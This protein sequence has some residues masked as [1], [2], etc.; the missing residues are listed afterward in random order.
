[1]SDIARGY[2]KDVNK[3]RTQGSERAAA[4]G[5]RYGVLSQATGHT[6]PRPSF[7]P[8]TVALA[9]RRQHA[10][11]RIPALGA[12]KRFAYS[13]RLGGT[14]SL[15]TCVHGDPESVIKPALGYAPS[16]SL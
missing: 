3:T 10:S 11:G 9:L 7:G 16:Q 15:C 13:E 12:M 6:R 4:L 1:M 2:P 5:P 8:N 14:S